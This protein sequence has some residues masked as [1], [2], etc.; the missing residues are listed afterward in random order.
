M[1]S[2]FCIMVDGIGRI[3]EYEVAMQLAIRAFPGDRQPGAAR[4]T[5][6]SACL[7]LS[8]VGECRCDRGA[9]A[10][11][12][13]ALGVSPRSSR[14]L[15]P[16]SG[17]GS[18]SFGK[19]HRA[20][21]YRFA[22]YLGTNEVVIDGVQGRVWCL[23]IRHRRCVLDRVASDGRTF[24]VPYVAGVPIATCGLGQRPAGPSQLA[25]ADHRPALYESRRVR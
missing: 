22:Q 2:P 9:H 6:I 17:L 7:I 5:Q 13:I 18:G 14:F 3:A 1:P 12:G 25:V 20:Q 24:Y 11:R 10:A 15:P 21:R 8:P 16:P 23:T 19:V 4:G